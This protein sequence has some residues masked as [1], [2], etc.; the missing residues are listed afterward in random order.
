M[1][2]LIPPS[3][4]RELLIQYWIRV[5][6]VWAVIIGVACIIAN[7]LHAPTFVL[8]KS[9]LAAFSG[10]LA[11][12]QEQ[13]K[14]FNEAQETLQAANTVAALL[15]ETGTTTLASEVV[16][17]LDEIAGT[18]I[19][20]ESFEVVLEAAVITKINITGVA[21]TR[22][23][24][25]KFSDDLEI[26]PLFAEAEVPISNLAKDRDISFNIAIVPTQ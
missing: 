6:T 12:A 10:E 17:V 16:N 24:L 5:A 9:Q 22:A 25:A 21:T 1:A 14:A 3:A 4:K 15:A 19:T 13:E 26:H 20:V 7:V 8:V 11:N 18:Q 2:N 23:A